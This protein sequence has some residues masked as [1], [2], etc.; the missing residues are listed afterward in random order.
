M[1]GK[2]C[3]CPPAPP[4]TICGASILPSMNGSACST[5]GFQDIPTIGSLDLK[6]RFWFL[7]HGGL[8][9]AACV[10]TG[11]PLIGPPLRPRTGG[12]G[13]PREG[14]GRGCGRCV[15]QVENYVNRRRSCR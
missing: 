14:K 13:S 4:R 11:L 8:N 15:K 3:G 10:A 5:I 1:V 12:G 7:A 2:N 9:E 6:A